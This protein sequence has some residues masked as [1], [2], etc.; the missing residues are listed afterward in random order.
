MSD[1]IKL[2]IALG[3]TCSGC[4]IAILDI[5]EKIL[6]LAAIADIVF[7]P[8]AADPKI[9]DVEA[10]EDGEITVTLMH[11]TI[12]TAEHEHIAKLMRKKSVVLVAFGSCTC[13]G[14]IPA[15]CNLT[16]KDEIF[17]VAYDKTLTT[18]N[19]EGTRPQ[20]KTTVN[21]HELTL[22]KLY[23]TGRAL[24]QV[25]DVDYYVPGCP[26]AVPLIEQLLGI[27]VNFV[28]TGELPPKGAVVASAKTVCDECELEKEEKT[29][30]GIKRVHE[31]TPD[32]KKC[33]MEQGL[34]CMG[35]VT[36][37]G[38]GTQCINAL[39]PC[40]GCMGAPEKVEDQGLKMISAL[41]SVLGVSNET[42]MT[43][44]DI[45]ELM[46]TVPDPVGTFYRFT[47]PMAIIDKSLKGKKR[48][49]GGD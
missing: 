48:E 4:D 37:G 20:E 31:I 9:K 22:P 43:R 36:R 28:K 27:V 13:D 26:P 1:K 8:T 29:V 33:L 18:V 14:G 5:D 38:C 49:T 2:A 40:R 35:P 24:N 41:A 45:E 12:R 16:T 44:E 15:L 25:V 10:M 23:D 17:D 21:G 34:I 39:M 7:W 47:L 11:G 3:S 32:P 19:P 6:D 42:D 30:D 46:K